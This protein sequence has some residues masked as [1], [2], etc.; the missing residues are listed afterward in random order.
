MHVGREILTAA[1][2]SA[3]NGTVA[4]QDNLHFWNHIEGTNVSLHRY[5]DVM[6]GSSAA[7]NSEEEKKDIRRTERTGGQHTRKI[8]D[9]MMIIRQKYGSSGSVW[10][11]CVHIC[12][13]ST[14]MLIKPASLSGPPLLPAQPVSLLVHLH[15]N[16]LICCFGW[17]VCSPWRW[18]SSALI[19]SSVVD[20]CDGSCNPAMHQWRNEC[21]MHSLP[22]KGNRKGTPNWNRAPRE[23]WAEG[24]VQGQWRE[25]HHPVQ[26]APH[27]LLL[28][29]STQ[30]IPHFKYS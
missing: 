17:T 13:P 4:Q 27:C 21:C 26:E 5:C 14:I 7:V 19:T 30:K 29:K 15:V 22:K 28:Y 12:V 25:N 23:R 9:L 1:C 24:V 3:I 8:T 10:P 2:T 20:S 16:V 6:W 18:R 11:W